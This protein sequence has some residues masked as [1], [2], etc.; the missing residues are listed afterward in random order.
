M[1]IAWLI[2]SMSGQTDSHVKNSKHFKELNENVCI[3]DEEVMVYFDVSSLFT[4]HQYM[5]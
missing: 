1:Y 3:G 2:S 5:R 4:K